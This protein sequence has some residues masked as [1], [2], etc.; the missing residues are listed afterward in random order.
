VLPL[1]RTTYENLLFQC[2]ANARFWIAY[3]SWSI[4][5]T[6][7]GGDS[8]CYSSLLIPVSEPVATLT[9]SNVHNAPTST[10]IIVDHVFTHKFALQPPQPSGIGE[11]AKVGIGVGVGLVALLVLGFFLLKRNR[12]RKNLQGSPKRPTAPIYSVWQPEL[13]GAALQ[14]LETPRGPGRRI[15]LEEPV[16]ELGP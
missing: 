1:V 13:D 7:L 8:P 11:T 16:W 10:V 12:R 2:Y 4:Y 5:S 15:E 6:S 9:S 3:R 14:E